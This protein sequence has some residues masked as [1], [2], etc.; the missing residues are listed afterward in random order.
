MTADPTA[1]PTAAVLLPF[2]SGRRDELLLLM[3]GVRGVR[4]GRPGRLDRLGRGGRQ[5]RGE[6]EDRAA[7]DVTVC[8]CCS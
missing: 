7:V 6:G 4:L 5:V 1:A 8:C 2:I 3:V